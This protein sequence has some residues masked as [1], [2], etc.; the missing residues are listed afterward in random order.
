[1]PRRTSTSPTLTPELAA[2]IKWLSARHPDWPQH[3]IAAELNL[4][5]G[6]VCEVLKGDRYPEVPPAP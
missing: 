2:R 3:R 5:Q 1:M 6:R 4:N